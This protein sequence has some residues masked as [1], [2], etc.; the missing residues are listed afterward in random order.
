MNLE[1][2]AAG[3]GRRGV[4]AVRCRP[5]SGGLRHAA[6]KNWQPRSLAH[7]P[8]GKSVGTKGDRRLKQQPGAGDGAVA[9]GGFR[10]PV[11]GR[12]PIPVSERAG[13]PG[14]SSLQVWA[15]SAAPGGKQ[16]LA[17]RWPTCTL[18]LPASR[19]ETTGRGL[20][21]APREEALPCGTDAC[22]AATSRRR[23]QES[24]LPSSALGLASQV[25]GGKS[26]VRPCLCHHLSTAPQ[27]PGA[28]WML[29]MCSL[30]WG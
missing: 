27:P 17:P 18:Q 30:P 4:R 12:A 13:S 6:G 19:L 7:W 2:R 16:G 26:Q 20:S 14:E 5:R 21:S 9:G 11:P 22:S 15:A 3:G 1:S 10:H 8:D 24:R 23:S 25:G 28:P 29:P